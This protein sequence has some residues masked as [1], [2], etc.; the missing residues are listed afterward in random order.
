[1]RPVADYPAR[2]ALLAVA[3]GAKIEQNQVRELLWLIQACPTLES[4]PIALDNLHR[5]LAIARRNWPHLLDKF[6]LAFLE[7]LLNNLIPLLKSTSLP[8]TPLNA[9]GRNDWLSDRENIDR[10]P[11]YFALCELPTKL[12]PNAYRCWL[13]MAHLFVAH[14]TVLRRPVSLPTK[15]AQR[16]YAPTQANYEAYDFAE[17]WGEIRIPCR[18]AGLAIR[19]IC[20]NPRWNRNLLRL[21]PLRLTPKRFARAGAITVFAP[22][23]SNKDAGWLQDRI[24]YIVNY[25]C[26]AYGL[27]SRH[28]GHGRVA[29]V[30][31]PV[32]PSVQ[33][34]ASS[35]GQPVSQP[36]D[37]RQAGGQRQPES[38]DSTSQPGGPP[39]QEDWDRYDECPNEDEEEEED[40][41]EDE[42]GDDD[43][44]DG[45]DGRQSDS[46]R[47]SEREK[48]SGDPVAA[49]RYQAIRASKGFAFGVD[50]LAP[51]ELVPL[52]IDGRRRA[53]D[54]LDEL[55]LQQAVAGGAGPELS[56]QQDAETLVFILTA[57]WTGS[58]AKRTKSLLITTAVDF[59][60]DIPI[61]CMMSQQAMG[62]DA[63]FRVRVRFPKDCAVLQ[64]RT[65]C[66]RERTDSVLLTDTAE[67]GPI[68]WKM[69]A[70][71][72]RFT[73]RKEE[74][75]QKVE[76]FELFEKPLK[77][78]TDRANEII[79]KWNCSGRLSLT[80]ISN[81][82]YGSVMSWSGKD[83]VA[84]TMITGVYKGQ[85]R[86]PM[87]YSS[88][89][90]DVL[91]SICTGT[92]QDLR[93]RIQQES[94]YTAR[95]N[96]NGTAPSLGTNLATIRR[97]APVA[98]FNPAPDGTL[99]VGTRRSPTDEKLQEAIAEVIKL[100]RGPWDLR[101]T[102]QW[103]QYT[104]LYTFYSTWFFG[105]VTGCRPI[106]NP[107]L[108]LSEVSP[109]NHTAALKDKADEK[110]RLVWI[111]DG[112]FEHM[113]FYA[114]YLSRTRLAYAKKYPCWFLDE[115][116][117]PLEVRPST[118]EPVLNRFLPGFPSNLH[119]R[120]L[121]NA[122]WDSGCPAELV[123]AWS[124][125]AT[126]GNAFWGPSATASYGQMGEVLHRY[127]TPI[128]NF[129]GFVPIPGKK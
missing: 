39:R 98:P 116:R 113:Q 88:R 92:V 93:H 32:T 62:L 5:V 31:P 65:A 11:F 7:P 58:S 72:G 2:Q 83:I 20:G 110:A 89:R 96:G 59:S 64:P 94:L 106:L 33:T 85:A 46:T 86:V 107:Y 111:A 26:Q 81:T 67:L 25:T 34:A 55:I 115:N 100:L 52:E 10:N 125:H 103:V 124:G 109:L 57:F 99:Y 84:T 117:K 74:K 80:S 21:F 70:L 120:W 79:T 112:L 41:D 122:L 95:R 38:G 15:R 6:G 12:S 17:P 23:L 28:R 60:E 76:S 49:N 73:G 129:L 42:H 68:L 45:Q 123:R 8:P 91:Q 114:D 61:A 119:R 56:K 53:N 14:V 48:Y 77:V 75:E 127:I 36:A 128:L 29:K 105:F 126:A 1:M 16:Q 78:Y 22:N 90:M 35:S 97:A 82:L 40:N 63:R 50:R 101:Q 47:E 104:N 9:A 102:E 43:T 69:A 19:D 24:D 13:L 51:C 44:E 66:D 121:M 3:R 27:K 37:R 108:S 18:H 30:L 71:Q 4:L 87:F 118:I 54:L